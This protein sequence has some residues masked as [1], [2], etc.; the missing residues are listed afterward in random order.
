MAFIKLSDYSYSALS[1]DAKT[2]VGVNIGARLIE[3]DTDVIWVFDG[4][5]WRES[6]D[7]LL[8]AVAA[9]QVATEATLAAVQALP[10]DEISGGLVAVDLEHHEIHE[11]KSY[12]YYHSDPD[13]SDIGD[14]TLIAF[15]TP[16]TAERIHML[17]IGTASAAA[18]FHVLEG[19]NEGAVG[20]TE[21]T[22]R[23]RDRNSA[24]TSVLK[25]ARVGTANRLATYVL[26]DAGNITGGTELITESIGANGQGQR[27]EGGETQ[28]FGVLILKQNTPY[29]YAIESLDNN[30][31][32]H[33]IL[34]A[35]HEE[36]AP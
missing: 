20:G 29:A 35:W 4:T 33:S 9:I 6:N 22:P 12:F 1:T 23:N 25:S 19:V 30:D 26:G 13:P 17:Y 32:V 15:K 24:N 34:L 31:N 36:E 7:V 21:V 5:A 10:R 16:D 2:T 18:H 14:R 8:D 28:M 27:T 3:Y 11:A